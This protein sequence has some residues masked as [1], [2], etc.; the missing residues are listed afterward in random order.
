MDEQLENTIEAAT[1]LLATIKETSK[2][3]EDQSG[4]IMDSEIIE[5][6]LKTF[7]DEMNHTANQIMTESIALKKLSMMNLISE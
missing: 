5:H 2:V 1:K 4:E 3:L 6:F 7:P